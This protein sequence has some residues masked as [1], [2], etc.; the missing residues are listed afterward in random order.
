MKDINFLNGLRDRL[1]N[2]KVFVPSTIFGNLLRYLWT[3]GR[4]QLKVHALF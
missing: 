2:L 4:V 3:R 1:E